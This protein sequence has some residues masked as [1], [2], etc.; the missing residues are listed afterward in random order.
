MVRPGSYALEVRLAI[1]EKGHNTPITYY[2]NVKLKKVAL[3]GL[4]IAISCTIDIL[5]F[6]RIIHTAE[7]RG[8]RIDRPILLGWSLNRGFQ[9]DNSLI[10]DSRA[11]G[12]GFKVSQRV[13]N[14]V[15]SGVI[16]VKY[17]NK[18]WLT[19]KR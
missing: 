9:N 17:L 8:Q 4:G 10:F 3:L 12:T 1:V 16:S 7:T 18:K 11:I 13:N 15:Y 6:N 19:N 2:L 5:S 14:A